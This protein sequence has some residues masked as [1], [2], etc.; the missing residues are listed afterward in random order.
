MNTFRTPLRRIE[1]LGAA[2]TGTTHFL[3]QRLTAAALVPLSVWFVASALAY[4]GAEQG[5]VAAFFAEPL[6]AILM[7]LFLLA[8]LYHMNLG[9]QVIIEDY[10]PQEGLKLT[11]IVLV[12][13]AAWGT[14]AA[15]GYALVKLALG[16]PI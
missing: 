10:F 4:V 15:C 6:N 12:R 5:A 14:G 9:L 7:A 3:R 13:F 2:K 11:L 16:T 8:A 1:G